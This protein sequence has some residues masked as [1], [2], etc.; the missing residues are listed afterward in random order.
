MLPQTRRYYTEEKVHFLLVLLRC[1]GSEKEVSH[2]YFHFLVQFQIVH[3]CVD[4]IDFILEVLGFLRKSGCLHSQF[5]EN[6]SIEDSAHEGSETSDH[7]LLSVTGSYVVA[8]YQN[9]SCVNRDQVLADLRVM[10]DGIPPIGSVLVDDR[11]P[12][13]VR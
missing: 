13:V 10:V 6:V 12:N 1:L 11:I 3:R 4:D 2:S 5:S 7:D 8:S 9:N